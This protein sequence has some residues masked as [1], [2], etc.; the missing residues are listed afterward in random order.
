MSED[1][2]TEAVARLRDFLD[3]LDE[4][5]RLPGEKPLREAVAEQARRH[6]DD[7]GAS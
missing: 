3:R 1:R 7:G 2:R 5:T 4:E 6:L